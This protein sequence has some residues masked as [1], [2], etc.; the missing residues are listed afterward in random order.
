[1]SH[2]RL[3]SERAPYFTINSHDRLRAGVQIF[4]QF[5]HVRVYSIQLEY[6]PQ[7]FSAN[8]IVSFGEV[9]KRNC[10]GWCHL[11]QRRG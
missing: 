7:C 5:D 4:S 1:M 3:D 9:H 6:L 8:A 2:S 10:K 11:I